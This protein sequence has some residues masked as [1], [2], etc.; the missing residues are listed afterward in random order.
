M[1]ERPALFLGLLADQPELIAEV[2]A[3]RWRA[4]GASGTPGPWIQATA[5]SAGR[6][7][8]PL[9]LVAMGLA[10][11]VIGAVTLDPVGE[12]GPVP[13]SERSPWALHMVV[14]PGERMCGVGR[15]IVAALEDLAREHGHDRLWVSACDTEVEFYRRC[16][17]EDTEAGPAAT[18]LSK[19]LAPV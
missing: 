18:V 2:G 14:R 19:R 17:W 16:G 13:C 8:L 15:L 4:S 7:S 10:G 12:P 6:D 9:T 1:R 5:A 11:E 3:L